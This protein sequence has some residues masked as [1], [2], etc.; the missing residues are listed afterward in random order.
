MTLVPVFNTN[1]MVEE[2]TERC[3]LPSHRRAA[4]LSADHLRAAKELAAWRR[5]VAG[6]WN[7]VRVEAVEAPVGDALRVGADFPVRVRVNLGA[8]SPDDVE[9]QLYHGVLDSMGDIADPRLTPLKI[10]GTR[11]GSTALFTGNVPC[12]AS[13]QFGFTVRVVPRHP[14]LP[15]SFEPGLVTWG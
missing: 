12:R 13:G 1:R 15:N 7:Q 2:Y 9:V 3:Y 6:V 8:V 4:K 10:D 11:N 5:R 14:N